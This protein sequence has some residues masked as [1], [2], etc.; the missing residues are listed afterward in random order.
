MKTFKGQSL[1]TWNLTSIRERER[2]FAVSK[3][4][5]GGAAGK[6]Y[7]Q[8]FNK[9]KPPLRVGAGGSGMRALEQSNSRENKWSE[10]GEGKIR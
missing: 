9:H 10:L 5:V 2:N 4:G 8:S 1:H 3:I 6:D 7:Y